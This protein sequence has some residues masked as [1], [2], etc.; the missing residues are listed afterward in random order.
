MEASQ[1]SLC[2]TTQAKFAC[3][4]VFPAIPLCEV[5]LLPHLDTEGTHIP[6]SSRKQ[7]WIWPAPGEGLEYCEDCRA[8]PVFSFC[9]C[10]NPPKRRCEDCDT[11][12][13]QRTPQVYHS[14]H[15]I[16]AYAAATRVPVETYRKKQ[17]YIS[18]FEFSIGEELP[19]FDAFV[20][21]VKEELETLLGEI[22]AMKES[23]LDNLQAERVKLVSALGEIQQAIEAKRY[24]ASAN[25]TTYLDDY[26]ETGYQ[27]MRELDLEMFTGTIHLQ[28]I[29]A[30]LWK[31][32]SFA[33]SSYR[34]YY[35]VAR[36]VNAIPVL[37]DNS[38]R[39]YDGETLQAAEIKLSQSTSICAGTAYC[40]IQDNVVL[41]CGGSAQNR[42]YEVNVQSGEV[43]QA[44]EMNQNREYAG[45]FKLKGEVLVFGGRMYGE[46]LDSVE[47]YAVRGKVWS[48]LPSLQRAKYACSVCK[49][50]SGLYIAGYS[51][52]TAESTIEVFSPLNE[53]CRLLSTVSGPS[54]ILC[55]EGN[56]LYHIRL[57]RIEVGNLTNSQV[58][59]TF[60]KKGT[61]AQRGNG[62][63]WLCF[64][65]CVSNGEVVGVLTAVGVP[66]GLFRFNSAGVH[67]SQVVK[68][69]YYPRAD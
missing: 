54:G 66:C 63:Y 32:V 51:D 48:V 37:R 23:L 22:T 20:K 13:S 2:L 28:E 29:R 39:L 21:Q 67:F 40:Y 1:C 24:T 33:Q 60:T 12:H 7:E 10:S 43:V 59:L 53:T 41:C 65:T 6:V 34:L 55:C 35:A 58:S 68:F 30:L 52:L 14:R 9:L 11:A 18:H 57:N 47:K 5:C 62:V 25:I 64:P 26:V 31:A 46:M 36:P 3:S 16:A 38:L 8:K 15:P 69:S 17:Q 44:A 45:I 42:V 49:H 27:D 61:I 19:R 4:C 56:E 50:S